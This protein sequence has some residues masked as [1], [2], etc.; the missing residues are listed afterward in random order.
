MRR[1]NGS[2]QLQSI[3]LPDHLHLYQRRI[4]QGSHIMDDILVVDYVCYG[5]YVAAACFFDFAAKATAPI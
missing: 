5:R 2:T 4:L 1:L 3:D